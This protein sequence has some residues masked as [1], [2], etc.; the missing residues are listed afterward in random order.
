MIGQP[1][2]HRQ[3]LL[4]QLRLF[5]PFRDRSELLAGRI[6]ANKFLGRNPQ[7]VFIL[8]IQPGKGVPVG[9]PAFWFLLFFL[10]GRRIRH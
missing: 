10:G 6:A 7:S 8:G 1:F 9:S 5:E 3:Q 2:A 4:G